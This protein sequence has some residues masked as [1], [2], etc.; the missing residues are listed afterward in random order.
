MVAVTIRVPLLVTVRP[1]APEMMPVSVRVLPPAT[2]NVPAVVRTT[3]LLR[4]RFV[5]ARSTAP[6][7]AKVT[8]PLPSALF[9]A[10]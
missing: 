2:L 6:F 5:A 9:A 4:V 10:T 7:D 8:V 3:A 1:L